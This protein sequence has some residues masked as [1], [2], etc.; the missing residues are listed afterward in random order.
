VLLGGQLLGTFTT[1][2]G[3]AYAPQT[4]DFT[5]AAGTFDLA[6]AFDAAQRGPDN[7]V[8]FDQVQIG[9]V[10]TVSPEPAT[11][12]SLGAGLVLLGGVRLARRRRAMAV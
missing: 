6:F 4:I 9:V 3:Q 8:F 7:T 1:V 11:W 2:T 10:P 5:T 12:V